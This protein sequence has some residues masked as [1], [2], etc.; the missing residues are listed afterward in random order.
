[1]RQGKYNLYLWQGK[2]LDMSI[3]CTTPGL[4]YEQPDKIRDEFDDEEEGDLRKA[5]PKAESL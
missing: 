4:F 5:L 1:M 3:D 2:N